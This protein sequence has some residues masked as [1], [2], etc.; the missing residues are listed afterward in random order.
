MRSARSA[1]SHT[2]RWKFASSIGVPAG[3]VKAKSSGARRG[4]PQE[5]GHLVATRLGRVPSPALL[6]QQFARDPCY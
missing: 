5:S 3:V 6:S 1:R 2:R 4:E